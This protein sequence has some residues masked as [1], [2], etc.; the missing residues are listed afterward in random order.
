MIFLSCFSYQYLWSSCN[1]IGGP[2][3]SIFN[4]TQQ[5]P[6]A[7][8][9]FGVGGGLGSSFASKP[10]QKPTTLTELR[11]FYGKEPSVVE[12]MSIER[13]LTSFDSNS[14]S[15]ETRRQVIGRIKLLSRGSGLAQ[16]RWNNTALP[17]SLSSS[18]SSSNKLYSDPISSHNHHH[19][20]MFGR[21]SSSSSSVG[22][23]SGVGHLTDAQLIMTLF[24]RYLDEKLPGEGYGLS[25]LHP[26]TSKYF[27]DSSLSK[28]SSKYLFYI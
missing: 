4:N 24:C 22:G 28:P 26:F 23:M 2:S 14:N 13:Y 8:N 18:S 6:G 16:F 5:A 3:N 7:T 20:H 12:R 25:P 11:Q 19:H 27:M 17:S 10:P 21:N 15:T 9:F 1:V